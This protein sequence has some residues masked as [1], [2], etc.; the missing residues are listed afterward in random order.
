MILKGVYISFTLM[1]PYPFFYIFEVI[2]TEA[3]INGIPINHA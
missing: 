1:S 3:K 2:R